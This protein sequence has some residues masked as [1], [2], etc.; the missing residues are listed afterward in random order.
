MAITYQNEWERNESGI[1]IIDQLISSDASVL[2]LLHAYLKISGLTRQESL[3]FHNCPLDNSD[4]KSLSGFVELDDPQ[5]ISNS[6]QGWTG[7]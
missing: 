4:Y 5:I 6:C 2:Y 7:R 1:N 3:R